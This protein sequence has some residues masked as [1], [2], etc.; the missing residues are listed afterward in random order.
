MSTEDEVREA[1]NQLYAAGLAGRSPGACHNSARVP[2]PSD[3]DLRTCS[4]RWLASSA[5]PFAFIRLVK[6]SEEKA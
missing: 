6:R 3:S 4:L 5:Q 1:S 2:A